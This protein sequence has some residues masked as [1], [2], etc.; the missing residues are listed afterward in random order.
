MFQAIFTEFWNAASKSVL[1][2]VAEHKI[3]EISIYV[4]G[5]IYVANLKITKMILGE[6][7]KQE[8]N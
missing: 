2:C 5:F 8:Y 3:S 7:L 4:Y 6:F 1:T